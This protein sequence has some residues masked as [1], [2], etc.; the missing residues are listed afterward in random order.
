MRFL[1]GMPCLYNAG[2]TRKSIESVCN[3]RDVDLLLVDNGAEQGVKDVLYEFGMRSIVT[4]KHLIAL[5][6]IL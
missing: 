5:L 6:N 2:L 3:E 4:G 1:L